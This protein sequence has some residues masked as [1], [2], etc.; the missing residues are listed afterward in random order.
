MSIAVPLL[1]RRAVVQAKIEATYAVA[2]TPDTGDGILCEVPEYTITPNI[3]ERDF[4]RNDMSPLGVVVARKLAKLEF[5]TELRGNSKENSGL[6]TDA[7]VIARLFQACGYALS[8]ATTS[9]GL[10]PYMTNVQNN[11]VTWTTDA[12]TATNTDVVQYI[13]TV[14][15]GGASGT[16]KITVTSDTAGEGNASATVTTGTPVVTGTKGISL[17][18]VFTGSLVV[19]QRWVVWLL[20]LG[21]LLTPR[22]DSFQSLTLLTNKDGVQHQMPGSFGTF[23][24]TMQAGQYAKVK[25]TF[26]GN[27]VQPTDVAL[28]TPVYERTIPHQCELG[29]LE[30]DNTRIIVSKFTF[31]QGN[32]IQ[33]LEDISSV[34]GYAGVR[35]VNRKPEGGI[36]PLA[37]TVA[38]YDFWGRLGSGQAMP[39]Q[40]RAGTAAGNA[41][42]FFGTNAQYS[43]MSYIDRNS[44]LA[45]QAGLRFAR[46]NGNDENFIFFA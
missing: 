30:A 2:E 28:P 38:T 13:L 22:S 41:V 7:P 12:T 42:W 39:F 16:A 4:T 29:R 31:N 3:L 32:D 15:T 14:D 19:G 25:F 26:T 6:L 8:G 45:Y 5:T 27:F 33:I 20:P 44:L 34:E 17:T 23:E 24:I 11:V 46:Q 1:T 37:E 36:D 9:V 43:G 18:P 35:I 10:G 21:L 40:V